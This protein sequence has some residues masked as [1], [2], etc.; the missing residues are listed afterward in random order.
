MKIDF[1]YR[2]KRFIEASRIRLPESQA[3]LVLSIQKKLKEG[4]VLD[5][6]EY[7]LIRVE[8]IFRLISSDYKTYNLS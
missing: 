1:T 8:G 4:L 5:G 3:K 6:C 2:G 7:T